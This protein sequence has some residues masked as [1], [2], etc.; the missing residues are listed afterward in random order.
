[1]VASEKQFFVQLNVYFPY[2][3]TVWTSKLERLTNF[4]FGGLSGTKRWKGTSLF[5]RDVSDEEKKRWKY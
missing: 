5:V 3:S 4:G 1:V 2:M